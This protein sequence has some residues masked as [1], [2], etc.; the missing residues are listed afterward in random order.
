MPE[1][2]GT[3]THENLK[4]AFASESQTNRRYL[5]FA[6]IAEIEGHPEIAGVFRD[7]ADSGTGHA[8]G[9]LDFLKFVGDPV[10]GMPMGETEDNLKAAL[11]SERRD[12]EDIYPQMALTAREEGLPHIANW[13]ETL[14]Q[15]ERAHASRLEE[16][17]ETI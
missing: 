4:R 12:A 9:H 10:T 14:A 13:F 6:K 8:H 16:R 1:I 17:L 3:Q 11:T 5:Y 7:L 2:K 15:A